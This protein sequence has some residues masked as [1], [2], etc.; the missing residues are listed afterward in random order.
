M[1][2]YASSLI[3]VVRCHLGAAGAPPVPASLREVLAARLTDPRKRRGIRHSLGSLVSVLVAGVACG[4]ASPLAIAGAAAGWEPDVLA[5][6][7]TRKN[8]VTGAFEP[9][10]ASS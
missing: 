3:E 2:V 6:H 5:A 7:G 4:Y 10:S 9:P 1:P 8:P